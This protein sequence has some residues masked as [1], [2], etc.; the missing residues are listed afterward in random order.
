MDLVQ[1]GYFSKTH[2]VKGHLLFRAD[3]DFDEEALKA[4]FIEGATGKAPYFI[5]ELKMSAN[6]YV[7]LLEEVQSVEA[8]KKLIGKSVLL[9]RRL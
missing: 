3:V 2:G 5:Q 7:V 8:A 4:L 1:A 6:Q 9:I